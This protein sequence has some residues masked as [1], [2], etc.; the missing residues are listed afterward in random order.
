MANNKGQ[1]FEK[2]IDRSSDDYSK[3]GLAKIEKR[4]TPMVIIKRKPN[5]MF[6]C[7]FGKKSTVDY[8][9]I[10]RSRS[11]QFEA[12]VVEEGDGT[13]LRLRNIKDHQYDHLVEC[14]LY[15]AVC[16][17]IVYFIQNDKIYVYP[18]ERLK[19]AYRAAEEGGRK[20]IPLA[21]FEQHGYEVKAGRVPVDYL[22]AVDAMLV[23][24]A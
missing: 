9:G 18:L 6:L 10:Y 22:V 23:K 3:M 14:A 8:E 2:L 16:F 4:A 7:S 21:E 19:Q 12:K 11:L 5:G 1:Y 13:A 20:S 24:Y 17:L 15:G